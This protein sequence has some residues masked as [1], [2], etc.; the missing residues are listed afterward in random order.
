MTRTDIAKQL[1]ERKGRGKSQEAIKDSLD[2]LGLIEDIIS[3]AL[4]YDGKVVWT[5]FFTIS[6]KDQPERKGRDPKTG[7]VI[8]YPPTKRVNCKIST[9]IKNRVNGE[10][11]E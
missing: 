8:T 5:G 2:T 7:D 6:V 4:V 3:D 1:A 11:M 10:I 9:N